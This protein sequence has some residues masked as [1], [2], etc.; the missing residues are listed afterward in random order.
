M[1]EIKISGEKW[2]VSE[3]FFKV[4]AKQD[5]GLLTKH[6][7]E[8]LHENKLSLSIKNS[9]GKHVIKVGYFVCPNLEYA[10]ERFYEERFYQKA[11]YTNII[12]EVKKK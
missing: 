8:L 5:F 7:V 11:N 2:R 9:I 6:H 12:F 4:V 1:S 3:V 10:N